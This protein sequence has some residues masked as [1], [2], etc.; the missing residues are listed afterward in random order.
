MA[1][2]SKLAKKYEDATKFTSEELEQIKGLQESYINVQNSLGQ[3]AMARLRLEKQLVAMNEAE[4]ELKNK[5]SETQTKEKD[6]VDSL[7]EKYGSGT[8]DPESGEFK[9]SENQ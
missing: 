6:L 9:P 4:I 3:L 5:F 1:E 8:L 2:E 7:S